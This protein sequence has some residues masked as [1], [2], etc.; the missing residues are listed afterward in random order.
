MSPRARR[1]PG[2]FRFAP[3]YESFVDVNDIVHG[4]IWMGPLSELVLCKWGTL[5]SQVKFMWR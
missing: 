4:F 3:A 2:R 5:D 1:G